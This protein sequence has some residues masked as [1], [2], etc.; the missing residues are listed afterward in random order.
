MLLNR[1]QDIGCFGI[2]LIFKMY[3]IIIFGCTGSQLLLR[4]FPPLQQVGTTL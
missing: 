4:A 1:T 3:F 2:L